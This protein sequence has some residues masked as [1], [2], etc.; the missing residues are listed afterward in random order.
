[1]KVVLTVLLILLNALYVQSQANLDSLQEVLKTTSIDRANLRNTVAQMQAM[2]PNQT[3]EIQLMGEWVIKNADADTL[4]DIQASAHFV[5]GKAYTNV[6]NFDDAMRHLTAAQN[7]AEKN[8]LNSVQADALNIMGSIYDRNEQNDIAS[9]YYEKS[10]VISKKNNYLRGMALAEFNLGS[11]QLETGKSETVRH[12]VNLMLQGYAVINQLKDTQNIISQ[13][14]GL[15]YAYTILKKYDSASAI[16]ENAEK[17][18]KATGKEVAYI[19][20]YTRVAKMYNDKKNYPAAIRYYDTGLAVAKKYNIPRWLCMY[21]SGLAETYETMGDYKQANL[22]NQLNIKMHDALVSEE[23]FIAAAD[24][25]NRYERVKKDNEIM[26]LSSAN[27]QKAALNTILI[28]SSIGLLLVSFL[29]YVNFKNRSKISRQQEEIQNQKIAELEKD[30]QLMAIDAM[31]KGQEEERSR[32]AKDLHD[33]LGGL[34]S[35]TKLSFM[36]VKENLVLSPEN[37][38]LFDRSL[39]M[40]DN[41]IGDLRK[42]AHNLMPE[43]LVKFG[44]HE[45]LRD[46]CNSIQSSSGLQ[47]LFQQFGENRKLNNT[48]EVFTYRIIQELVNNAIKHAGATR[49]IAQLTM[50]NDKTGITV[51]D[52]GKGFDKYKMP[53]H[54]GA[55]ISNIKYRVQY[56]NGGLDIVTSPG[57]GTSV[58]IELMV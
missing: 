50:S 3:K 44:L 41:T 57:N 42:T 18:I 9:E 5:L 7:I 19:R 28:G 47:V 4:R 52:D 35:G 36:T 30:K 23:N 15:G 32:I 43:A 20:H 33:G 1:M 38:M 46:F 27:K 58:N 12:A 31:L 26:K 14:S 34:L 16:L 25:Q 2:Y 8:N 49:I 11:V 45:A 24:I 21:Y 48:A 29:G 10:F 56:F 40:L 39:S 51:E 13:S 17:L 6:L 22:Y 54:K 53:H 55:G 37:S